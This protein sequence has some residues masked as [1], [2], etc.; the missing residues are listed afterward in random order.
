M[1]WGKVK[2]GGRVFG[3]MSA[4]SEEVEEALANVSQ[5]IKSSQSLPPS[6]SS[7]GQASIDGLH[8]VRVIDPISR[9]YA[10]VSSDIE[11]TIRSDISSKKK[12]A[13]DHETMLKKLA[14]NQI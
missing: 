4:G 10:L 14:G 7:H 6:T 1:V 13:Q 9:A 2:G 12:Q 3:V 5:H 8:S 11:E